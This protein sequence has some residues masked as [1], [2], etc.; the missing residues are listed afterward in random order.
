[1]KIRRT[2]NKLS[3]FAWKDSIFY[4]WWLVVLTLLINAASASPVW[5][6]VGV[7]ID[8]L[9]QHFGW[10]R[11]QL[12]FAFS[13][14]QLEGSIVGPLVGILVD[15]IGPKNVV[16]LGISIIGVGFILLSQTQ[17][18][19]MFYLSYAIIMMGASGGGWLPMMTVINN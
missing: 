9:E 18:L 3:I 14:G 1:M 4:G 11:T 8:S 17:S 12:S 13:L 5:G 6:G 19:G 2:T 10:S 16:F 7:W 15:R